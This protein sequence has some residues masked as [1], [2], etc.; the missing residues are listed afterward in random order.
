MSEVLPSQTVTFFED[1]PESPSED[2]LN[3]KVR[4]NLVKPL[5]LLA[6]LPYPGTG[7]PPLLHLRND[8]NCR[9][10]VLFFPLL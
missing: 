2:H 8:G 5:G 1:L 7:T 6:S 10:V 3:I 4:I 9:L